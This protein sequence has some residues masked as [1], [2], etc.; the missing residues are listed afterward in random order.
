LSAPLPACTT[1]F[2]SSIM[3]M[4]RSSL[5]EELGKEYLTVARAKGVG[6]KAIVLRHAVRNALVPVITVVGIQIGYMLGGTVIIEQ[7]FAIPDRKSTRLNSSH[8]S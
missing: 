4:M 6:E 7:V 3:R 5:L 1:L 2:R 8:V